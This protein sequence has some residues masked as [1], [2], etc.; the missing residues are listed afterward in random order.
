MVLDILQ[1]YGWDKLSIVTTDND[2]GFGVEDS[3]KQ[4]AASR[5]VKLEVVK[6]LKVIALY[7][8]L[9]SFTIVNDI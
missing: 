8:E 1:F 5:R 9:L 4:L 2:Y 6:R 3:L 7:C